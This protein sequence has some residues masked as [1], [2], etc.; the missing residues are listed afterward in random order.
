VTRFAV[1]FLLVFAELAFGGMISLAIPPFSR[2]ERGFYKSSCG[3]FLTSGAAAGIGFAMLALR[4]NPADIGPSTTSLW[5]SG[6][7]WGVFSAIFALY[8]W[9]LWS[10][11][12]AIRARAYP[13][14]LVVG[15]VA[16]VASA[17]S[18]MPPG[19]GLVSAV[20][21]AITAI[22]SSLV[23]GL[24][25]GAMLFGHWYL[26]DLDMPVD[27]IR[28]F[29]RILT[30][31][32]VADAVALTLVPLAMWLVGTP[33]ASAAATEVI[34]VNSGLL[35]MRMLFGPVALLILAWMCHQTLKIPQTMAAT[36]LLYVALM[37]AI[38]GEMLGR[39]I[40]FRT[41]VPL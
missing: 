27:Y 40:L 11:A 20:S 25:C 1:C 14:G 29:T 13:A 28:G 33:A 9:T 6:A 5:I 35:A 22:T 8:M 41:S 10:D 3:V 39:F 36:G 38:V 37:A 18:L 23:L 12:A 21:F 7:L 15:L 19:F 34:R 24:V 30:I 26:I 16:T 17:A 4:R 31:A 32:I 2:I